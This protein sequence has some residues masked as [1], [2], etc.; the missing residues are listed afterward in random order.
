MFAKNVGDLKESVTNTKNGTGT[1]MVEKLEQNSEFATNSALPRAYHFSVTFLE[2][3]SVIVLAITCSKIVLSLIS[4]SENITQFT[5][6]SSDISRSDF[7]QN[8]N[9]FRTLTSIDPFFKTFNTEQNGVAALVPESS[10]DIKIFGIRS[11][12]DGKGTAILKVQ[13][14]LQKLAQIGDEITNGVRLTA[15]HQ[16]RIEFRRNGITETIYL[17]KDRQNQKATNNSQINTAAANVPSENIQNNLEL[18]FNAMDLAPYRSGPQNRIRGFAIG[19]NAQEA[20]I[21]KAGL[22][23]G[24]IIS[25]INGNEMVSWES[26]QEVPAEAISGKLDIQLERR[27]ETLSLSLSQ[28]SFGQ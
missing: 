16:N 3:I 20:I 17:V 14:E 4:P 15:V 18:I 11:N 10:L 12:G 7:D 6:Y 1:V 27:G 23:I 5:S 19:Q 2:V 21:Y 8:K 24:D 28:S 22:E 9:N 25:T 13:G 26:I